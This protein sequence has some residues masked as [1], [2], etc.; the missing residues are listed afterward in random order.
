MSGT[1]LFPLPAIET[2]FLYDANISNK[3]SNAIST[4]RHLHTVW[5]ML[6]DHEISNKKSNTI[7]LLVDIAHSLVYA[8]RP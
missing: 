4:C 5:F 8:Q 3:I 7:D 6:K 1:L 2:H